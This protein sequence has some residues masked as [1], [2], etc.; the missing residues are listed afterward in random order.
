MS[1]V[2]CV[3]ARLV[4]WSGRFVWLHGPCELAAVNINEPWY[5]DPELAHKKGV[6]PEK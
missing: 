4:G 6:N 3:L 5:H 1:M 2:G